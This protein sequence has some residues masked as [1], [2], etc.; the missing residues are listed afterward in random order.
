MKRVNQGYL[1][2]LRPF[3]SFDYVQNKYTLFK[4][5]KVKENM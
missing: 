2:E 4:Q 3:T 5:F 1:T